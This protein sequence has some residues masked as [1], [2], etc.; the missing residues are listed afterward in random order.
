MCII[1]R[2]MVGLKGPIGCL[3]KMLRAF[4]APDHEVWDEHPACAEF[5]INK[6]WQESVK[7]TPFF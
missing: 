5:A 3:E 2:Q 6:Y 4:F 7:N 1:C